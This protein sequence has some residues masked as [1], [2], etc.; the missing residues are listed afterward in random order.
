MTYLQLPDLVEKAV[1]VD[2]TTRLQTVWQVRVLANV[3]TDVTCDT[4]DDQVPGWEDII[5]SSDGRLS[6]DAVGVVTPDDPCVI[7]P[8]GGY[9]GLENRLY[10]VEI[11][12]GGAAGTATFK[13]SR[14][15]ASIATSVTALTALDK[16]TVARVGRDNT[17]RFSVGDWIEITDDF[18]EF[19]QQPGIMLQIK[20][21][22]D[23]TQIITLTDALLAG[24][25]PTDAQGNTDP[26]RHTRI[27]RWDHK[28]KVTDTNNNLLVDL[29]AT[30]STGLIPVPVQGTSIILEDGVQITFNTPANGSYRVGDFW[31]SAARTADA[32]VERLVEAPPRG[33]HHHYARLSIVTFPNSATDCR[34]EWP[35]S[36]KSECGC[37]CTYTVGDG[38]NSFGKYTK[39]NDAINALPDSG[40]EV[41]ILPGLYFENVFIQGRRDVVLR[42]CGW[43]TRI[44]SESLK[45]APPPADPPAGAPHDA[46]AV[47]GPNTD[48][49]PFT[50]VITISQSQH[51]K[52]LSFA[53]EAA[54]DEV[55]VLIDGTGK[56]SVAPQNNTGA[57]NVLRERIII[58][59][60]PTLDVTVEDLVITASTVPA[61]LADTVKL[62]QIEGNRI[63]MENVAARWPA[64]WVSGNEI[65]IVHNW[66]GIQS[67][68]ADLEWLPATVQSDI[69]QPPQSGRTGLT[70]IASFVAPGGIQIGGMSTG[71]ATRD[72]FIIENEIDSAGW[73]GITLGSVAILDSKG[74]N[75]GGI[76]GTT[77]QVPGPCDKTTIFQIPTPTP[78]SPE[79]ASSPP[80]IWSTFKSI[81]IV[82]ATRVHAAS[83]RSDFSTPSRDRRLSSIQ[84]LTISANTIARTLLREVT[85]LAQATSGAFGAICI[86]YVE[87]LVVQ[88]QCDH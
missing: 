33:I 32:S 3:G 61:I 85:P 60:A 38:V 12:E 48:T 4:P 88:R 6:T 15:N 57:P 83:G 30:G 77:V 22:D 21:V 28:G 40:G 19:A 34:T 9:R 50:A 74:N 7:P 29:D 78:A 53:V 52:L 13:W 64:V 27:R 44:A 20:D 24:T 45:P 56:L 73:N 84:N 67:E 43:Q 80:A 76:S 87:E 26:Q 63:A 49:P 66:L 54:E 65:R 70:G 36:G 79:A 35:P 86:P 55:G 17:L 39:I 51:V 82:S 2:T 68:A 58:E 62:L 42:G 71:V 10:R 81:A 18:L 8:S 72:V 23:A 1:G 41:C 5:H 16:L 25:F 14:D 37:C 31:C 69:A 46:A 59:P 75:T 47:G 11:H